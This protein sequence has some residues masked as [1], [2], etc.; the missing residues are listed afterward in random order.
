ML[1]HS[2]VE[3]LPIGCQRPLEIL[4]AQAR[5]RD[6]G[7]VVAILNLRHFTDG[8]FVMLTEDLRH[9]SRAFPVKAKRTKRARTL[10]STALPNVSR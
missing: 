9:T 1:G 10:R 4:D 3:H 2:V 5:E 7:C 6:V 8:R